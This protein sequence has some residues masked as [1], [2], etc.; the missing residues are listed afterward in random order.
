MSTEDDFYNA[1]F[2]GD[3][4]NLERLAETVTDLPW[5]AGETGRD[6]L[7]TAIQWSNAASVKWVLSRKPEI[8]F[9]DECGFTPLKQ[10]L[11]IEADIDVI[12][13][14]SPGELTQVTVQLIDL[15]IEAGAD[16]NLSCTLGE[17]ILHTAAMWSSPTVIRHL[18]SLG[19]DPMI[20]DDEYE[21]RQP[22]YYAKFFKRWEAHTVLEEAM[23]SR[24]E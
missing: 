24:S 13:K 16:I 19:A 22:I 23:R 8:N 21:P 2:E 15:L 18:L 7:M 9:I 1:L 12:H 17:S 20:F 3:V 5:A 4:S 10:V 6:V 14:Q 11:Q